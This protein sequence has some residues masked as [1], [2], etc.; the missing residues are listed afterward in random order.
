MKV[1]T[2]FSVRQPDVVTKG[3]PG[4]TLIVALVPPG[5][6]CWRVTAARDGWP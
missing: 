2:V 3:R 6:S 4:S 1:L 5:T